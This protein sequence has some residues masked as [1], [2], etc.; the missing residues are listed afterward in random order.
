MNI[1]VMK[2]GT[3]E[4]RITHRVEIENRISSTDNKIEGNH[5]VNKKGVNLKY[6]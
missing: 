1:L 5:I 3:R 6:T 2:R 4:V